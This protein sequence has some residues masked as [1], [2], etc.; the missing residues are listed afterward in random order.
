MAIAA[1]QRITAADLLHETETTT[2]TQT[3]LPNATINTWTD[4]GTEEITFSDPGV[5]VTV[6][7]ILISSCFTDQTTADRVVTRVAISFDGGSTFDTSAGL[8]YGTSDSDNISRTPT[9]A[10]H[11]RTGT[12][13]GDVVVKAQCMH[14]VS[15][16]QAD[17]FSGALTAT[18][19]A[20]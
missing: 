12:P 6:E 16:G 8:A 14:E 1:G 10:F 4:F 20:A 5:E 15:G 3:N 2:L 19:K 13:T 11:V 9:P 7:A 18:I 17:F